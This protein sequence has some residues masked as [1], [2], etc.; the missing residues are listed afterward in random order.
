[1]G[2]GVAGCATER[3]GACRCLLAQPL[4]TPHCPSVSRSPPSN[5]TLTSESPN[6]LL[7]SWTPPTGHVLH[8]RL[9]YTLASG[10]GPEKSVS[11]GGAGSHCP[12]W[13]WAWWQ[14]EAWPPACR[15]LPWRDT[16]K[17]AEVPK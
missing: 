16:D 13:T 11:L 7:V 1:M 15:V 10:S 9:T 3:A 4:L 12:S 14:G 2:G 5:L 8:Y 6:S 17:G